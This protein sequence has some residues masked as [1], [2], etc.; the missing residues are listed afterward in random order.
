MDKTRVSNWLSLFVW[1]AV[2]ML[3]SLRLLYFL[4]VAVFGGFLDVAGG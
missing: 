3:F 2:G 4:Y 1:V